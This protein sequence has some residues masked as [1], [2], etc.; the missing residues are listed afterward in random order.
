[1]LK[2]TE[3]KIDELYPSNEQQLLEELT[4]EEI[5]EIRGGLGETDSDDIDTNNISS[6]LNYI[7]EEA[8]SLV[9]GIGNKIQSM[10]KA[11]GV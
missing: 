1:M 3:I 9:T 5:H 11:I 4:L 7:D 2:I 8:N 6:L 10:R